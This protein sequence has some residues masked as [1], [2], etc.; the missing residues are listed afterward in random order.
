[1]VAEYKCYTRR[2]PTALL[3]LGLL[4]IVVNLKKTW[5]S[6]AKVNIVSDSTNF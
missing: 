5:F 6:L 1:M 3:C 2:M 4:V